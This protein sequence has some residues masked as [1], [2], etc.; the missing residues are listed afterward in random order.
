MDF[1]YS[2]S[3]NP[4]NANVHIVLFREATCK[5]EALSKEV[6]GSFLHN[7]DMCSHVNV[8]YSAFARSVSP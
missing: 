7:N 8:Q 5:V 1:L 6:I 3:C 2:A 4:A